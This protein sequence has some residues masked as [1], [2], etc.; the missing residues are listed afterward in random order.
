MR[1]PVRC[2]RH[3][4]MTVTVIGSLSILLVPLTP[5]HNPYLSALS[6][7]AVSQS[8]ASPTCPNRG[9]NT[10]LTQC[11]HAQGLSCRRIDR[12]SETPCL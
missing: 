11:V 3:F 12:C 9:C 10:F 2:A 7:W 4:V 5:T 1:T 6:N 8:L